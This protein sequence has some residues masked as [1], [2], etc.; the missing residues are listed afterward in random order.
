MIARH[1]WILL[2]LP[3]PMVT[4]ESKTSVNDMIEHLFNV[5]LGGRGN[6][7]S[8]ILQEHLK[9]KCVYGYSDIE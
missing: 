8:F 9:V 2:L 3:Y 5:L 1:S 7:E 4:T 6:K